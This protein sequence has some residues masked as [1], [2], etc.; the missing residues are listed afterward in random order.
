MFYKV[1]LTIV[2]SVLTTSAC[3][4]NE[5]LGLT[6]RYARVASAWHTVKQDALINK[7][8]IEDRAQAT[9]DTQE[10]DKVLVFIHTWINSDNT[11]KKKLVLKLPLQII[12]SRASF[13]RLSTLVAQN[14]DRFTPEE[15]TIMK[16]IQ[17]DLNIL[18][19]RWDSIATS[20]EKITQLL[21]VLE[22]VEL[23]RGLK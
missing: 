4:I 8:S 5:T 1:L 17:T 15:L 22:T 11:S 16:T 18:S 23:L 13:T 10:L 6:T 21:D 12:R 9:E 19:V 2:L 7:L 14:Q 3:S 20:N